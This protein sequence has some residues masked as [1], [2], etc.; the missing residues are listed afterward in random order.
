MVCRRRLRSQASLAVAMNPF[1]PILE[2]SVVGLVLLVELAVVGAI[3]LTI[4]GIVRF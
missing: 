4:F 2:C 3:I 1:R